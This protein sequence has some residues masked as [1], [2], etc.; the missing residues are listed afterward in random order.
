MCIVHIHVFYTQ[1]AEHAKLTPC[2]QQE[3]LQSI[4]QRSTESCCNSY[5]IKLH[6]K[7]V[8][9][10]VLFPLC[11]ETFFLVQVCNSWQLD[12]KQ[13][14]LKLRRQQHNQPPIIPSEVSLPCPADTTL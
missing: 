1:S 9:K 3:S 13:T 8:L 6:S 11:T 7:C 12:D 4:S 14:Y 2:L 10:A 5:R